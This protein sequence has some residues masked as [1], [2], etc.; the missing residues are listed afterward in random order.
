MYHTAG[1]GMTAA[2][3]AAAANGGDSVAAAAA[4]AA[5]NAA[6]HDF[7]EAW[8]KECITAI[9]AKNRSIGRDLIK[10]SSAPI[11]STN[12]AVPSSSGG[13]GGDKSSSSSLSSSSSSSS[14]LPGGSAAS[15]LMNG[16]GGG[17]NE[18]LSANSSRST[19]PVDSQHQTH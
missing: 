4:A 16:T 15:A 2:A 8:R 3:A 14:F 10:T 18:D 17:T 5:L 9:D 7:E 12:G 1:A 19:S 6:Y 11:P 13:G